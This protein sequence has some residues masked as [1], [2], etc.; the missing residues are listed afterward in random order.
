MQTMENAGK[1]DQPNRRM[2]FG[3]SGAAK[4]NAAYVNG[5]YGL[6]GAVDQP[7][8][9][10]AFQ[11]SL[12]SQANSEATTRKLTGQQR[13]E[14]V[15][16][17]L[18]DPPVKAQDRAV[19][20][21]RFATFQDETALGTFIL[22][23]K[24]KFKQ[25]GWKKA[26]AFM[27]FL[28]PFAG[29][30]SSVATRIVKR[31][32]VGIATEISKQIVEMKRGGE[33][34]QRAMSQA[35]G[36]GTAALPVIAAGFALAANGLLTGGYPETDD[37]RK[38][39]EIDGKQPN[40]VRVG[41][42]W[43]SLNYIQPF[44][45]ILNVGAGMY[46]TGKDDPDTVDRIISGV[47]T[48]TGSV[49]DQSYLQ[50]LSSTLDMLDQGAS[51]DYA[52]ERFLNSTA[53][54]VIPNFVRSGVRA[55]DDKQRQTNSPL[56]A[57]KSGIPGLRSTLETKK[58]M[59]GNDLEPKD[60][61]LNQFINPLKPSRVKE[62][63]VTTQELTRLNNAKQGVFP[64]KISKDALGKDTENLTDKQIKE[65]GANTG[66]AT[67]AAWDKIIATDEY[68]KLSDEDKNK[69]LSKVK[70]DIV[71]VE[72]RKYAADKQIGEYAQGYKGKQ[73][74]LSKSQIAL[75][76]G[77]NVDKYIKAADAKTLPKNINSLAREVLDSEDTEDVNWKTK[78]A[79]DKVKSTLTSWVPQG[80]EL[81]PFNNDVAKDWANMEK[82]RA[83]GTLGKL[84]E[85]DTRKTILRKA[86][87]SQLNEDEK[88]LYKL[89]EARLLDA[90]D[91][92]VINEDNVKKALAVEKQL[93]NAGLIDKE[94]LAKKL[95][96][97]ARGYKGST[98][99][100][101]SG[102]KSSSSSKG[103]SFTPPKTSL[104]EGAVADTTKAFQR[105]LASS[106][107]VKAK[108]VKKR[109]IK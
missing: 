31:T 24:Q 14:F 75:M 29:V 62:G 64:S 20:E 107:R 83:E 52:R 8:R 18:V 17:F 85:E 88:D 44:G 109:A 73:S 56:D 63:D 37:E 43:W 61:F 11:E 40:S 7:Y 50:G 5:V 23:G 35:I 16:E 91:R 36:E 72:K 106:V 42:R 57:V 34:D 60:T 65:L 92:G 94:S 38:Q 100:K 41:G 53:G 84:E 39:W 104:S 3:K 47:T 58:D 9:Y 22:S 19:K 51:S 87:N 21:A 69:V 101:S 49:K 82:K 54:S 59:F 45:A 71:A 78:P 6:M 25:K 2:N 32:P 86:Y 93:Y 4:A 81:P 26:A 1:Y 89:S 12:S 48:G 28:I 105:L 97:S 103:S 27:D 33:F 10:G 67:K 99:R 79:S 77:G 80:A 108:K 55:A 102:R 68:K 76:E 46:N 95:D 90:L 15:E 74:T 70:G 98:G 96:L 13:A 66:K 30:P